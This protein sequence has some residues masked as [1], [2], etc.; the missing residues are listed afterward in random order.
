MV[1]AVIGLP[2]S[3]KTFLAK[4]LA[5]NIDGVHVSSDRVRTALEQR[6]KYDE[7]TKL[8][9]YQ[10]MLGLAEAA[11]KDRK[12]VVLDATFHKAQTRA[13]FVETATKFKVPL[14]FIEIQ[15]SEEVIKERIAK[16]RVDSEA[17]FSIYK[18]IK[19]AFEPLK[20]KHLILH[21]DQMDSEEMVSRALNYCK[22]ENEKK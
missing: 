6:G 11:V 2:G 8:E 18:K 12:H 4:H 14:Y 17:D 9:V 1:V 21:S 15:A 19:A 13:L 3:G 7:Q 10:S 20:E 16:K 5:W 22:Y